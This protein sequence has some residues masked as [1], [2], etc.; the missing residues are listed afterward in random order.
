MQGQT[1]RWETL[2]PA[3]IRSIQAYIPSKPDDV[4]RDMFHCPSIHRLNN[5]ENALG[6]A[7]EA[8]AAIA[9]F[10]PAAAAIYPSGDAFHLRQRLA[11]KFGLDADCFLVGNGANEVIAFVIN[12][13]CQAGDNIITADKTFAVYE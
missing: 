3:H 12:A 2:V 13:F 4:L 7:K 11:Q 6:P 8:Q 5:N 9:A 10:D 1:V